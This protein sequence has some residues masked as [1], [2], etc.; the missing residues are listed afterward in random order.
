V[1]LARGEA[2]GIPMLDAACVGNQVISTGWGGQM[3]FLP[4]HL[5][6]YIPWRWTPVMQAY[7]HFSGHQL[8]AEPDLMACVEAMRDLAAGGRRPKAR[9]DMSEF[10]PSNIAEI[11]MQAL[12]L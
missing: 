6:T 4:P 1:S 10:S 9:T 8:W 7:T 2:F 12:A 5:T 11:F 3:D